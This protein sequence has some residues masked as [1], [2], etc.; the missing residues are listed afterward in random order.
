VSFELDEILSLSDRIAVMARGRLL[1]ILNA[2]E[3]D[4]E[5]L[6]LL[7]AGEAAHGAAA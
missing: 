5:L 2:S 1:R 6:G 3:A 4:P 7:M